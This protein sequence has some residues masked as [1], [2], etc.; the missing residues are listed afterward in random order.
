MTRVLQRLLFVAVCAAIASAI[1]A[2]IYSMM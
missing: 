1:R 2:A